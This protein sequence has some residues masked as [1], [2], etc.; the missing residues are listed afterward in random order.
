MFRLLAQRSFSALTLTQ[1]LGAFNDNAFKQLV[2]LLAASVGVAGGIDWVAT[3][4][5]AIEW[6]QVLPATLFALPF[7]LLG[8]LT[9]SLADRC[10]KTT[11]IRAANLL[12]IVVMGGALAA[13]VL[14]SYPVLLGVLGAMGAQSALF[15]PSKY[16]VIVEL[17]GRKSLSSGNAMIQMTTMLAILG[18]AML[19]G[20]LLDGFHDR[21]WIPGMLYVGLASLGWLCSLLIRPLPAADP[22]RVLDWNPARELARHWRETD[23]NRPLILVIFGSAFFYLVGASLLLI[24]NEAGVAHGLSGKETSLL[25]AMTVSGIAVGSLIAGWVSR[26][27]IEPGLIPIGLGGM[28]ACLFVVPLYPDSLLVLRLALLGLG[29]CAGLFTIPVRAL[30]QALPREDKRGSILGLSEVMDF[31]G[32]L[33]ASSIVFRL[34][35]AGLELTPPEMFA[36]MGVLVLVFTVGSLVYTAEFLLRLM[37]FLLTHTGYRIR[38]R[39]LQHLPGEGG[40]LLVANH[41]SFIDPLLIYASSPRPVRFLV[42][43]GYTRVPLIGWFVKKMGA[44]PVDA[45]DSAASKRAALKAASDSIEAGELVCIFAEGAI[46]RSGKLLTFRRGLELIARRAEAPIVPVALDRLWGSIFS[47]ESGRFFWKWPRRFPY[48]VDL[49]VGEP[50]PA[51]TAAWR[52]RSVIQEMISDQRSERPE[53][54]DLAAAFTRSACQNPRSVALL[55]SSGKSLTYRRLLIASHAL[56]ARLARSEEE[57]VAVLLPPGIGGA[58]V[59]VALAFAGKSVVNLNYT[60]PNELLRAQLEVVGTRTV[61]TSQKFLDAL[62]RESPL[63]SGTVFVEELMAGTTRA[64]RL[65]GLLLSLLPARLAAWLVRSPAP[66]CAA[67]IVFSSGSTGEPKGVVLTQHNIR[68]NVRSFTQVCAFER[69][70]VVLGVLPFFHSFGYTA[71]L[72][73]PLLA[74]ARAVFHPSPLEA[75]EIG[76]LARTHAASV[77]L[78][79]PTFYQGYLRRCEKEDFGTLRLCVSGAER[80]RPALAERWERR[81]GHVL[82]EGYGATELSPVVALNVPDAGEPGSVESGRQLGSVGRAVPGVTIQVRDVETGVELAPSAEGLIWVKGPN[83]MPGYLDRDDLTREVLVDGWY[84]TGDVGRVD[85]KG[86][87]WLTDR[88]ARFSKIGGEMVPHGKV[89]D[90]LTR[91]VSSHLSAE[92]DVPELFVTALPDERKG[93]RLVV[94]HTQLPVEVDQLVRELG[95]LELPSL[96]VPRAANFV[97]VDEVPRLGSGKTDLRGAREVAAARLDAS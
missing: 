55:D 74:G 61:I 72:W 29:I 71:T 63:A 58:L 16:G 17:V 56:G 34:L 44:I 36:V 84:C 25:N 51:D 33:A 75:R 76:E 92:S 11:V 22:E 73:A 95:A 40:A 10:S 86:F 89:E 4:P 5:L 83:V 87:V 2:L 82:Y 3:H 1:F 54:S 26:D 77:F 93:E 96:F 66:R 50:L 9:G 48:I 80:L 14:E 94:L 53:R 28:A 27:R 6:G 7:V 24:V 15:G 59:N 67:A 38:A 64:S 43:R 47:F 18:G 30:L 65:C 23:G 62:G 41:V 20:A 90:E 39:G 35:D 49:V 37:L 21:L 78:A 12:E 68:E 57:R 81:F 42:Y 70:D 19:G 88:L 13:F 85:S 45:E 91:L 8:P 69:S 32:I 60:L 52:V 79:T 46:T 97:L 31:I